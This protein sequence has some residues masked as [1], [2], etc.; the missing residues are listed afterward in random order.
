MPV[1]LVPVYSVPPV[2]TFVAP[3]GCVGLVG[4]VEVVPVAFAVLGPGA[5]LGAALVP[6]PATTQQPL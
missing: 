1:F 6:A 4:L 3:A 2:P 5:V